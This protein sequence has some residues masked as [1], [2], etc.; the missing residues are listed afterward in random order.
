MMTEDIQED[1]QE[2]EVQFDETLV[3]ETESEEVI[4]PNEEFDDVGPE[5]CSLKT[6]VPISHPTFTICSKLADRCGLKLTSSSNFDYGMRMSRSTR[7]GWRPDGSF[8]R[9][10]PQVRRDLEP[11]GQI[12][13]QSRPVITGD[14]SSTSV[15]LL[16]THHNPSIKEIE[17][18]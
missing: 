8:V 15:R 10:G 5:R 13:V 11:N 4:F 18:E 2:E 16:K 14:K 3:D 6:A 12:L 7:V 9:L 17:N 1:Y